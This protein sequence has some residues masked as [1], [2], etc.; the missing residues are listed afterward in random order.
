MRVVLFGTIPLARKCMELLLERQD[1]KLIGVVADSGYETEEETTIDLALRNEIPIINMETC[2]SLEPD[3]GFSIRFNKILKMSTIRAFKYGIVNLHGGP[4]PYYR[5]SC[6]NILAI[7]NNEREFGV[8]LHYIDEG[9]D[10]GDV[11]AVRYFPLAEEETGY[12]LYN[13]TLEHGID[14]FEE[15]LDS[16]LLLQNKRI[17]QKDL[18]GNR[19]HYVSSKKADIQ[20]FMKLELEVLSEAEVLRRLRAFHFPGKHGVYSLVNERKVLLSLDE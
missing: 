2:R 14:L 5:G 3:L 19:M 11:I 4:L 1:V 18:M 16:I 12:S 17:P 7:L 8:S 13:K 15:N 10:T 20:K 6:N 9:I